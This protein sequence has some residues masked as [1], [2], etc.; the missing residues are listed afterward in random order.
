M[1][2]AS[3]FCPVAKLLEAGVNVAIGTDGSASNNALDMVAEMKTAAILAKAVAK[4]TTAVP[5]A[6]ALK[7]ATY[8]GAKALGLEDKIGSLQV[9]KSGDMIAVELGTRAANA[10]V[11]DP[12]SSFVYSSHGADVS[13]AWVNGQRVMRSRRVTTMDENEILEK[14]HLWVDKIKALNLDPHPN[15]HQKET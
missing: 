6:T 11:F 5:A 12:I 13:D 8:N 1:K 9:G 4:D 3:G 2:L 15:H 10:P 7:M 14:A